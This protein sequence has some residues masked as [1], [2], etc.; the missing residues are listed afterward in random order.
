MSRLTL[1]TTK[2]WK[3]KQAAVEPNLDSIAVMGNEFG[4]MK[5]CVH[6]M[7]DWRGKSANEDRMREFVITDGSVDRDFDILNPK[8]WDTKAFKKNPVVLFAHDSSQLPIG[9]SVK[10]YKDGDRLI[11][12]VEFAEKD[13]HPLGDTVMRMFDQKFL[14]AM[15]VGFRPLDIKS[16]D[17]EERPFG[18]DFNKSELL[19]HSAVP[20]PANP[21]ALMLA[22]EV[23]IDTAPIKSWCEEMLDLRGATS[24]KGLGTNDI[25]AAWKATGGGTKTYFDMKEATP[26]PTPSAKVVEVIIGKIKQDNAP[27]E[28]LKIVPIMASLDVKA[29]TWSLSRGSDVLVEGIPLGTE[30]IKLAGELIELPILRDGSEPVE[31]EEDFESDLI[32]ITDEDD[33]GVDKP[34][35]LGES[36]ED[37]TI[38]VEDDVLSEAIAEF[39]GSVKADLTA[40]G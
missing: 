18:L 24:L 16:S 10:L 33:E 30:S 32:E 37:D 38:E 15:S 29:K 25:E 26:A 11:S 8:G 7:L 13:L 40:N 21:N 31:V 20:I 5:G 1:L 23:G 14:N 22:H 9:R 12:R 27:E 19:E 36:S 3:E 35:D 6:E 2:T 39:F 28:T 34:D 4:I 17:D